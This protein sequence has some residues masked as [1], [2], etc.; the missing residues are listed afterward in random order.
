MTIFQLPFKK[1]VIAK[2]FLSIFLLVN[3][4]FFFCHNIFNDTVVA[5]G[6]HEEKGFIYEDDIMEIPDEKVES[7]TE[8]GVAKKEV[9]AHKEMSPNTLD[10]ALGYMKKGRKH[11]ARNML[12]DLYFTDAFYNKRKE[13]KKQLDM[14]N[15]ELIFSQ[16][17]SPDSFIYTVKAGDSLVKIASKFNTSHKLIMRINHKGRSL[18]RVG[19]RLKILKGEISLLVDKSDFTLTVLLDGHYIKQF[20]VGIGKY[21]KTPEEVFYIKDKLKNPVWY[22]PEGVFPFGHPKNLLGTRWMGFV[23]KEGLYGYGI[24]GTADPD[25]IGK[26]MSNGCIRLKNEDVE[27]LFDFVET[28]TKVVIQG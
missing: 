16:L 3:L 4:F 9:T 25:S 26:A 6:D 8:R 24:H 10:L 2:R 19:E 21:N 1:I 17:P 14:L 7:K 5:F 18:I 22:S 23:E 20:P 28:K 12:S 13:I 27:E 15:E 11:E